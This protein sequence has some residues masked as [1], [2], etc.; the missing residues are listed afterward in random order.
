MKPLK[1]IEIDFSL[2][3]SRTLILVGPDGLFSTL[4]LG[5]IFGKKGC[6]RLTLSLIKKEGKKK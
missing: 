6:L 1:S 4:Y 2:E 3:E 5:K